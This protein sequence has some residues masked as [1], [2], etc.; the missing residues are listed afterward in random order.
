MTGQ[1]V[2]SKSHIDTHLYLDE[3]TKIADSILLP[4][5]YINENKVENS[6]KNNN[7]N[8]HYGKDYA[9]LSSP[10]LNKKKNPGCWVEIPLARCWLVMA[11]NASPWPALTSSGQPGSASVSARVAISM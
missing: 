11:N 6:L 4:S 10:I 3:W 1:M 9:M 7:V 5:F 2:G 8:F